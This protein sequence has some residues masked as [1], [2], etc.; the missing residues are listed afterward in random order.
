MMSNMDSYPEKLTDALTNTPLLCRDVK[1]NKKRFN[2][3]NGSS[4]GP[5]SDIRI[6][7]TGQQT[8]QAGSVQFNFQLVVS[9]GT[10]AIDFTPFSLF[11]QIRVEASGAGGSNTLEQCD[12]IGPFHAFLAQYTWGEKDITVHSAKMGSMIARPKV[13][14]GELTKTGL[15]LSANTYKI[16]IDLS[17]ALG[18]FTQNI[19]LYNT[20]GILVNFRLAPQATALVGAAAAGGTAATSH[21]ITQPYIDAVCIEGGDA[22]EKSLMMMKD[23]KSGNGEVSIMFNTY[24]RTIQTVAN[25]FSTGQ[26]LIAESSKSCLGF[27]AI[28]RT[29]A[30]INTLTSYKNGNSGWTSWLRHNF[31]IN[32]AQYPVNP[33]DNA[34]SVIDENYDLFKNISRSGSKYGLLGI[35][36]GYPAITFANG[37]TGPSSVLSVNLAKCPTD[38]WGAGMNL[39]GNPAINLQVDYT[40]GANSTVHIYALRQQKVHI[41][42][43]GEFSVER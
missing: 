29:T 15:A 20:T 3:N 11:E 18:I 39:S 23:S 33:I 31:N 2:V 10:G 17:E 41:N 22:Y 27:F 34:A 36:Q 9:G 26:L 30:D 32:G 43:M 7:L 14:D 6:P 12:D 38:M 8:I 21:V 19:P 40:P 13:D 24:S 42:A 37:A 25:G 35:K 4:F 16:S 1:V 28:N 5:G